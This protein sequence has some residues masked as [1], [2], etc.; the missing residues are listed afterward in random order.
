MELRPYQ[1]DSIEKIHEA[2]QK[3]RS[4]MFQMPTGT[5]KTVIFNEIA[6]GERQQD[7]HVLII[8]HRKEIVEQIVKRLESKFNQ[9]VGII[10]SQSDKNPEA[11]IQV[12]SIQTLSRRN[13]PYSYASKVIID[14]AHHATAETY[15]KLWVKY[16]NAQFLGVTAT[17]IRLNGEGFDDLFNILITSDSIDN[18]IKQDFL[19]PI[20]Y[21]GHPKIIPDLRKIKD[22]G[23]DFDPNQLSGEMCQ[24]RIMANLIKSYLEF[25]EGKK[26]IVFAVDIQHSKHIVQR[27][28]KLGINAEHIDANKLFVF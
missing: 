21:L 25:A 26:I 2:W 23:G 13:Y 10:M 22:K 7:N 1:K 18:F 11:L 8:A 16:P 24:E 9:S 27:Y 15:K 5:G 14:E 12:A 19:A 4:I 6:H 3:Y 17:P 28:Q 20:K